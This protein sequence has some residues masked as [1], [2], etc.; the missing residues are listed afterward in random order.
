MSG[1]RDVGL[2]LLWQRSEQVFILNGILK[3]LVEQR[4]VVFMVRECHTDAAWPRSLIVGLHPFSVCL[5]L[6][7]QPCHNH[8]E[9][10]VNTMFALTA[11]AKVGYG[12]NLYHHRIG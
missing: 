9:N 10:V 7:C 2:V 5:P 8:P 11:M 1:L 6:L 12:C 4:S 3:H